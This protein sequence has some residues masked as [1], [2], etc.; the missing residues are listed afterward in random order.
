MDCDR[1][2]AQVRIHR[3][4]DY[5]NRASVLAGNVAADQMRDGIANAIA[6]GEVSEVIGLLRD[7]EL[8]SWVAYTAV[9]LPGLTREQRILCVER[10][11]EIVQSGGVEG[12]AAKI[13]LEQNEPG[14]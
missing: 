2:K 12:M 14:S 9:L 1:L 4:I 13:W 7:Q 11:K 10:I 3:S 6:Q 8:G 5:G